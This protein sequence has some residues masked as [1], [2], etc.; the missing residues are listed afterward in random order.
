MDFTG[1]TNPPIFWT[2]LAWWK[3]GN[4]K[5]RAAPGATRAPPAGALSIL[6]QRPMSGVISHNA[7]HDWE[8]RF[9]DAKGPRAV[10]P[11]HRLKGVAPC[12]R[13]LGW[14]T[15][16]VLISREG[17]SLLL[18][19]VPR[20]W[21]PGTP[22]GRAC[23]K[24]GQQTEKATHRLGS[25]PRVPRRLCVRR[26]GWP[27][28]LGWNSAIHWGDPSCT[29]PSNKGQQKN[30]QLRRRAH[31]TT[32]DAKLWLLGGRCGAGRGRGDCGVG[33]RTLE[34]PHTGSWAVRREG[35]SQSACPRLAGPSPFLVRRYWPLPL[36]LQQRCA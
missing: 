32:G 29:L 20:N 21:T 4:A 17:G 1:P 3:S 10:T 22:A 31:K 14:V 11:D 30:Q 13:A 7:L 28:G 26:K 15:M 23:C 24:R 27:G 33:G 6:N 5:H 16:R 2:G 35:W 9:G 19:V 36:W 8:P 25:P 18:S 12:P 34:L